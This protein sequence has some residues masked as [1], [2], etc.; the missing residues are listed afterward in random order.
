LCLWTPS[1]QTHCHPGV[2]AKPRFAW[3]AGAQVGRVP[4]AACASSFCESVQK[5]KAGPGG[6]AFFYVAGCRSHALP[7]KS[8]SGSTW[9]MRR[10]EAPQEYKIPFDFV[11][12]LTG[13]FGAPWS[14]CFGGP[15]TKVLQHSALHLRVHAV[16]TLRAN[17]P[18]S[19]ATHLSL[20]QGWQSETTT[21]L[22]WP[23]W[24][25]RSWTDFRNGA[26]RAAETL[27]LAAPSWTATRSAGL[28]DQLIGQVVSECSR[29]SVPQA[30]T[31]AP[32]TNEPAAKATYPS[33][34]VRK[35]Q[36]P[37]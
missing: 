6:P 18:T 1:A 2:V 14:G 21:V 30:L 37:T 17:G 9:R 26:V 16:A 33:G 13:S 35:F 19:A 23:E 10:F 36:S 22:I 34:E 32:I 15:M 29:T 5:T 24:T 8:H 20:C 4:V 28:G 7:A 31:Q 27:P 12:K 25:R 3:T 11:P